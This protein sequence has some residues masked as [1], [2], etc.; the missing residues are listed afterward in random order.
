MK[1]NGV[2]AYRVVQFCRNDCKI[3]KGE[4]KHGNSNKETEHFAR[5][6]EKLLLMKLSAMSGSISGMTTSHL[7]FGNWGYWRKTS[8]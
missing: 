6:V 8:L 3:A 1:V 5:L 7:G 2:F 4:E